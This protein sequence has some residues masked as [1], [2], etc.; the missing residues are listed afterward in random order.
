[1]PEM[2]R[3]GRAASL[4]AVAVGLWLAA[5]GPASAATADG[6][7]ITNLVSLSVIS[8]WG[9]TMTGA[10]TTATAFATVGFLPASVSGTTLPPLAAPGDYVTRTITYEVPV[11]YS[12]TSI[13]L[14]DTLPPYVHYVAGSASIAPDPGWDPD[15]GPPGHVRWTIPGPFPSGVSGEIT[16]QLTVDWGAGEV[17]VPGSGDVAAPQGT[18]LVTRPLLSWDGGTPGGLLADP[19]TTFVDWFRLEKTA[20]PMMSDVIYS[21]SIT[22]PSGVMSWHGVTVWDTVPAELDVWAP[23]YGI[24]DPCDTWTMTPTGCPIGSPSWIAAG[25]K[26][27]LRWNVGDLAP[28]QN[29]TVMWYGRLDPGIMS[30]TTVVNTAAAAAAGQTGDTGASGAPALSS[31]PADLTPTNYGPNAPGSLNARQLG[32]AVSL[33]WSP[34]AP[35]MYAVTAYFVYQATCA[36]CAG[37]FWDFIYAPTTNYVDIYLPDPF[38]TYWYEITALDEMWFEGPPSPRA[39]ASYGVCTDPAW[40]PR[41]S[42]A[43]PHFD[44]PA[45]AAVNGKLIVADGVG[46]EVFDPATE[47]WTSGPIMPGGGPDVATAVVAGTMYV[48]GGWGP[49][50]D[51]YAYDTNTGTW[52]TIAPLPTPRWS[53]AGASVNGKVYVIGGFDAANLAL[54]V[55]EEYDPAT[56]SWTTRASMP[57]A[58]GALAAAA[59]AGKIYAIGGD[60]DYPAGNPP[61]ATVEIYE[62]AGDTW[63]PGPAMPAPRRGLSAAVVGGTI[64]AVGGDYEWVVLSA[65]DAFDTATN[66]W[67]TACHL[68]APRAWAGAAAI[69]GTVFVVGGYDSTW[70]MLDTVEA[71]SPANPVVVP[72]APA[73]TAVKTMT[74]A[75]PGIGA[76]VT[77][78]ITVA[79]TGSATITALT[80]VDTVSPL[81]VN[82][83][84]GTPAGWAAP[85]VVS[86]GSGTR[87]EWTGAGLLF[88][89]GTSTTFTISGNI[90]VV[91]ARTALSNT[92]FVIASAAASTTV[93]ATNAVGAVIQPAAAGLA[94]VKTQMPVSP[95]PGNPVNYTIVVTNT[96][97]AT[98]TDLGLVDTLPAL[99]TS[100]VLTTPAGFTARPAAQSTS[101]TV[102][103]WVNSAPFLPGTNATFQLD[104][105][106]GATMLETTVCNTAYVTASTACSATKLASNL[107]SFTIPGMVLSFS[108]VKTRTGGTGVGSPVQYQIVVTN[109]GAATIDSVTIVDTISP[110]VTGVTTSQPGGFGAPA[111]ASVTGGT[112]YVW[113]GVALDLFPTQTITITVDGMVGAVFTPTAVSNTAFVAA[114]DMLADEI[115][116]ASNVVGFVVAPAVIVPTLALWEADPAPLNAKAGDVV[117]YRICFSNT[118]EVTGWSVVITTQP[119]S[120]S[121]RAKAAPQ[122]GSL[123]VSG[124][125]GSVAAYWAN[126]LGGPWNVTADTGMTEP[127]YLRWILGRVGMQKSGFIRYWATV[128]PGP[129][130]LLSAYASATLTSGF[131]DFIPFVLPYTATAT[132]NQL[133]DPPAAPLSLSAVGVVGQ[134]TLGW[135]AAVAGANPLTAYE[136]FRS[137]CGGCS[138]LS[139][140]TVGSWLAQWADTGVPVGVAATYEVMAR[141]AGGITGPVSAASGAAVRLPGPVWHA[142][143]TASMT[144]PM[145]EY[146]GDTFSVILVVSNQGEVPASG[147]TPHLAITSGASLVSLLSGPSPAGPVS[148]GAGGGFAFTWRYRADGTGVV[149]FAGYGDGTDTGTGDPI[150]SPSATAGV[151]LSVTPTGTVTIV[152]GPTGP[153]DPTLGQ[154][155]AITVWPAGPGTVTVRL[156]DMGGALIR[157]M[158]A[159]TGGGGITF[160]WDGRDHVNDIVPPGGYPVQITGPGVNRTDIL[161]VLY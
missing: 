133:C 126:S 148:I 63:T 159:S 154:Q 86:A 77:F 157:V 139:V 12:P 114:R 79:N 76:P 149:S 22:N 111:V 78:Q 35:G 147:V 124:G 61:Y 5:P 100:V 14:F 69:S 53:P 119:G 47:T 41:A 153:I 30:A 103:S 127:H 55:V 84:A 16:Y 101:G 62:P 92:A 45:V 38:G 112:R 24:L 129:C 66:T 7:I 46:T 117:E 115:R 57:T 106:V 95:T 8:P 29:V 23:G 122:P 73:V 144:W 6:T 93:L 56:G 1:M 32:G 142:I 81:V 125:Y 90:G 27:V 138:Y 83:V 145:T 71:T 96:G 50:T 87:Y 39:M 31:T 54:D 128:L 2:S 74:P 104:G 99:V 85:V 97:A 152:G 80:V 98:I 19:A 36:T 105:Y 136:I 64:Y 40:Y 67:A 161:G 118:S 116:A 10:G 107:T 88:G 146:V 72:P 113:S 52:T 160:Y 131:P 34:P 135:T 123:W 25:G 94:I 11:G 43:L 109:T 20:I 4:V 13:V 137:T 9:V 37:T 120:F 58:R 140:A 17:F 26:T 3:P 21:I 42:T 155:V 18:A 70:T 82:A 108:V 158:M 60:A 156:Y 102:Y 132:G 130:Q 151:T 15:P 48:A 28:G 110:V 91:C 75:S 44:T 89:P 121:N 33:A 49:I 51:V 134:I 65:V 68:N 150:A 141:D 143:L 59:V